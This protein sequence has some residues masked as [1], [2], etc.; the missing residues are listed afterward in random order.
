M[1]GTP[2]RLWVGGMRFRWS[3]GGGPSE[4]AEVASIPLAAAGSR[5]RRQGGFSPRDRTTG[6]RSPWLIRWPRRRREDLVW[7]RESPMLFGNRR[8]RS[9]VARRPE[10]FQPRSERLEARLLL[11]IDLG[12]QP[13]P[14][15]PN[16]AIT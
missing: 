13:P 2:R 10:A 3:R 16:V 15:L 8:P 9:S 11:A 1:T 14:A 7:R 4:I 5:P 12:G 6:G